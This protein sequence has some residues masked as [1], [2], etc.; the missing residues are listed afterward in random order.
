MFVEDPRAL[1]G[2][3]DVSIVQVCQERFP[4]EECAVGFL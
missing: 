4:G 3:E 1:R 2:A